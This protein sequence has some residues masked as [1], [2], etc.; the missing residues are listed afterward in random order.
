MNRRNFLEFIT[1]TAAVFTYGCRR[2]EQKI[3]SSINQ[4]ENITPGEPQYYNSVYSEKNFAYG[5]QIKTRDGVPIK[6]DGNELHPIN[7][8]KSTKHMQA[9]LYHLYNPDRFRMPRIGELNTTLSNSLDKI[10]NILNK[11][12]NSEKKTYILLDEYSS[13]MINE[14]IKQIHNKY[15]YIKVV[16]LSINDLSL[17]VIRANKLLF[18]IESEIYYGI[19]NIDYILSICTDFLA[20]EK[21][22][23]FFQVEYGKRK[24]FFNE[25]RATF[26]LV[27]IEEKLSLTGANSNEKHTIC[28]DDIESCLIKLANMIE[29]HLHINDGISNLVSE[30]RFEFLDSIVIDLVENKNSAIVIGNSKLSI[31]SNVL[32]QY[33]NLILGVYQNNKIQKYY[34]PFSYSI[35][36]DNNQLITDL[37]NNKV[38]NIIYLGINQNNII[39]TIYKELMNIPLEKTISINLYDDNSIYKSNINIPLKHGFE[40]WGDALAVD[41]SYSIRQPVIRPLN[42]DS[43]SIEEFLLFVYSCHNNGIELSN[44]VYNAIYYY[45]DILNNDFNELLKNGY[46]N[47]I[48]IINNTN[49]YE[50][51]N[52]NN[53]L[54][55]ALDESKYINNNYNNELKNYNEYNEILMEIPNILINE[56]SYINYIDLIKKN[57]NRLYKINDDNIYKINKWVIVIDTELCIGCSSCVM[58]CQIENNIKMVGKA[59]IEKGRS[60]HW[61]R[62][63]KGYNA[64]DNKLIFLPIMCQ[65]CENAPCENVCPVSASTHSPEGVNETIYNRCIGS[66]ICMTNCPYKARKFNYLENSEIKQ[67]EILKKNLEVTVR[68]RGVIEKCTM[69]I[70]R[71]NIA[72]HKAD[73]N[74]IEVIPDGYVMTACQQAC[75]TGAIKFGNLNEINSE[76]FRIVNSGKAFRLLEELGVNPS[77]YYI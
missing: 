73:I 47:N 43:I 70:N 57:T 34:S 71:I 36:L 6:V 5:I 59:A 20:E 67:N 10:N 7:N 18:N 26:K 13:P 77:V 32:I 14:L 76:V 55:K 54:L 24:S 50:I 44:K 45:N 25:K 21:Y 56:N 27:T 1:G 9:E 51:S 23:L 30:N 41:G 38:E 29:K 53:I 62:I 40:S 61:I 17:N 39:N 19:K 46:C 60:M 65:H 75:P 33:I 8:G 11:S 74:N 49:K 35:I 48:D 68:S 28:F 72:R 63:E 69:C 3:I 66:R 52:I 15:D 37:A 64:R 16:Q 22:S 58:A 12:A 4:T 31:V 42:S 2:P